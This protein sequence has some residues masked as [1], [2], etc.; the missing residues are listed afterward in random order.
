MDIID[1][2]KNTAKEKGISIAFICSK[3]GVGRGYLNDVKAGKNRLTDDRLSTI[4]GIL[5]V[6]V[7]YLLGRTD[8][9]NPPKPRLPDE[10]ASPA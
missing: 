2:I 9:P 4:A 3:L 8:D 6:S 5:G 10:L 7:D 1:K